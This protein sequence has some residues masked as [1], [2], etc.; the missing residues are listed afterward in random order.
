[1]VIL[2][3][4]TLVFVAFA[5]GLFAGVIKGLVGFAMPM[6]LISGLSTFLEPDIAL[7]ALIVPTLVTNWMQA[8]RQGVGEALA[9]VKRFRIFLIAGLIMLLTS[10]QLFRVLPAETILLFIGVPITAFAAI[11]L[12][13]YEL[14][15][16]RGPSKKI[17]VIV[18]GFAGF[19]GGVSGVWGPPTVAYLNAIDTEK[20]EHLRVQGVIY[21]LGAV[22]LLLAH[23]GSGVLNRQTWPLS[24]LMVIPAVGGTLIGLRLQDRIDQRAFRKATLIVLLFAG[25]NLIRRATFNG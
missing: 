14:R 8:L 15:L 6:I 9:S 16:P 25:L 4:P 2:S 19:I 12:L 17:E 22:A 13:G 18:G 7:A 1:M 23:L 24:L 21:G 10:A 5:V 20:R 3:D 11:Q